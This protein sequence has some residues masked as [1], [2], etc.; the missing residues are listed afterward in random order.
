MDIWVPAGQGLSKCKTHPGVG[1]FAPHIGCSDCL[2]SPADGPEDESPGE[3]EIACETASRR[4][5]PDA[6]EV[7]AR[8]WSVWRTAT[9]RAESCSLMADRLM[10]VEFAG[11]ESF[12]PDLDLAAKFEA[13]AAKWMDVS[14]KAGKLAT[15]P[16]LHRERMFE[17]E[18]R[19][20]LMKGRGSH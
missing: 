19:A 12:E 7:E 3:G 5:L 10:G 8:M 11:V 16:V 13:A 20:R 4:G 9:K 18:K 14:V 15:Q 6:F 2:S 17:L 1:P